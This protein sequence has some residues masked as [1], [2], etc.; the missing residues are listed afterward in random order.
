M[1]EQEIEDINSTYPW[2]SVVLRMIENGES[3]SQ[4]SQ[5][6]QT[7]LLARSRGFVERIGEDMTTIVVSDRG[8]EFLSRK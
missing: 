2:M 8:R 3:I 6:Y 5:F 1:K 7:Y 4:D